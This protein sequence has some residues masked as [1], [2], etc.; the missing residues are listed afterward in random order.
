LCVVENNVDVDD[1]RSLGDCSSSSHLLF[2]RKAVL[3]EIMRRKV[4]VNFY[5]H[6]EEGVLLCV[7]DGLCFVD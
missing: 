3:K 5:C 4:G 2:Y 7:S 6:I 1:A